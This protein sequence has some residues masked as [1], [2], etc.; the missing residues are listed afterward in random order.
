MK[1]AAALPLRI[2]KPPAF[3]NRANDDVMQSNAATYE[4]AARRRGTSSISRGNKALAGHKPS[5][6]NT[7]IDVESLCSPNARFDHV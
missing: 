3:R 7:V 2:G 4:R 5:I 1:K 6:V